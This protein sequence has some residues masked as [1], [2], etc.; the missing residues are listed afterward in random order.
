MNEH[1]NDSMTAQ[2]TAA[3]AAGAL[4]GAVVAMLFAPQSGQQTRNMVANKA[5]DLK[6]AAGDVIE[7]GQQ[8]ASDVAHKASEAY[9]KGKEMA[10]NAT[11]A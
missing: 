5:H 7:R 2:T 6:D 10:H 8:Y 4:A 3:F 9:E 1:N 11:H